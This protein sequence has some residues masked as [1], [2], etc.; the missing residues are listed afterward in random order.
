MLLMFC[1]KMQKNHIFYKQS[2]RIKTQIP[3]SKMATKMFFLLTDINT[4]RIPR[5]QTMCVTNFMLSQKWKNLSK[6]MWKLNAL[7]F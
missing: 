7:L 5:I 4:F 1:L 2:D 3:L 6:K